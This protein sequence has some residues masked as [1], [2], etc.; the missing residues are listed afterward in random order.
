MN[1]FAISSPFSPFFGL[2]LLYFKDNDLLFMISGA[3]NFLILS[4]P[5]CN[6]NTLFFRASGSLQN[7]AEGTEMF[8]ILLPHRFTASLISIPNQSGTFLK[9]DAPIALHHYHSKSIVY[10]RVHS[11]F[12]TFCGIEQM[13]NHMYPLW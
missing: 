7:W 9:I 1:S 3:D 13:Y 10:I 5:F 2:F 12:Y 4:F 8:C 6:L 11:W